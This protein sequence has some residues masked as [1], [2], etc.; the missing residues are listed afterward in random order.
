M[1]GVT[2]DT[3]KAYD[4]DSKLDTLFDYLHELHGHQCADP[5]RCERRFEAIEKRKLW[6]SAAAA[7]GGVVGGFIAV[8]ASMKFRLFGG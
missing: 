2:R 3:F 6:Y 1:N 7:G 8:I 4:T 5:E